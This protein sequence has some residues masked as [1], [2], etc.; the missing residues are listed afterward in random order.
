MKQLR[1]KRIARAAG[2]SM[3]FAI[4]LAALRSISPADA[5]EH[6]L[7]IPCQN[8]IGPFAIVKPRDPEALACD[9]T[10]MK[11]A[12]RVTCPPSFTRY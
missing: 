12:K 1:E 2:L 9:P 11:T 3:A 5:A 4:V 10:W 8:A 6:K 7:L